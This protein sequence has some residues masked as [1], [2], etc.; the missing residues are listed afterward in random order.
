MIVD[1]LV[2][3]GSIILIALGLWIIVRAALGAWR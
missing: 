1:Y 2:L 3:Y